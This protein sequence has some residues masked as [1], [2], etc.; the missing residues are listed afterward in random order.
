MCG[1]A[2][3]LADQRDFVRVEIAWHDVLMRR[4]QEAMHVRTIEDFALSMVGKAA[5]LG[6]VDRNITKEALEDADFD[7]RP[8]DKVWRG[9]AKDVLK[10][11]RKARVGLDRASKQGH[12]VADACASVRKSIDCLSRTLIPKEQSIKALRDAARQAVKDD[13]A[14]LCETIPDDGTW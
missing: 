1:I 10:V 5:V 3:Y 14:G 11:L 9:L 2:D 12:D 4:H 8:A 13:D 7:R 6:K